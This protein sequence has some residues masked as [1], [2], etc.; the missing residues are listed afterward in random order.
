MK[1]IVYLGLL[2]A[3]QPVHSATIESALNTCSFQDNA[4]KRLVCY[5]KVVK[6][7]NQYQGLDKKYEPILPVP[8]Q[9]PSNNSN[10]VTAVTSGAPAPIAAPRD[11]FGLE[12]KRAAESTKDRIQSQIAAVKENPYGKLTLTLENGQ[13]WRQ[14]DSLKLKLK[15]GNSIVIKRAMLGSFLLGKQDSNKRMRVK[16]VK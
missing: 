11:D 13:V 16:R 7:L 6:N 10:T 9:R 14:I 12:Q 8:P 15:V 4:L 3:T 2:L 1:K 5:D